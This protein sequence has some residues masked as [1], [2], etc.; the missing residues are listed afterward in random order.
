LATNAVIR[1]IPKALVYAQF[2]TT[3]HNS[4][5]QSKMVLAT[6]QI[7][8]MFAVVL[9]GK[10]RFSLARSFSDT[11]PAECTPLRLGLAG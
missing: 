6:T 9:L 8:A 2:S 1:V 10:G 5:E 11:A 4:L 7:A 3:S